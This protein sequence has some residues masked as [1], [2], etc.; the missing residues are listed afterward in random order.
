M[1]FGL[2]IYYYWYSIFANIYTSDMICVAWHRNSFFD[3]PR[4]CSVS[5]EHFCCFFIF[6]SNKQFA[7]W[8]WKRKNQSECKNRQLEGSK[9]M[10]QWKLVICLCLCVSEDQLKWIEV[11]HTYNG[12]ISHY[13]FYTIIFLSAFLN[14][15]D[16]EM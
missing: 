7:S 6:R 15:N 1:R 8:N 2:L 9:K 13:Y 12:N 16:D 5:V 4:I 11:R 3:F 14:E 10:K